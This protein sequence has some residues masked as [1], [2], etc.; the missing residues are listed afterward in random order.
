[1]V[2]LSVCHTRVLW[3]IQRAYRWYFYATWKGNPS[4][5]IFFVQLSSSWQDFSWLKASRGPSAVAERLVSITVIKGHSHPSVSF[6]SSTKSCNNVVL[7]EIMYWDWHGTILY[8]I[9]TPMMSHY[10]FFY[11]ARQHFKC[12]RL[13]P[14]NMSESNNKLRLMLAHV[15]SCVCW[16]RC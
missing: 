13:A 12:F 8:C 3:L 14:I 16:S 4:S 11:L 2:I 9:R 10:R 6:E 1:M 15:P 5:Q 7:A